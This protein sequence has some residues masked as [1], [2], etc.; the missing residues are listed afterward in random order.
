MTKKQTKA[1][2]PK[3]TLTLAKINK[4]A[5]S[6]NETTLFEFSNGEKLTINIKFSDSKIEDLLEEYGVHINA[7]EE[8]MSEMSELKKQKFQIHFLH[9]MIIKHFSEL[10]KSFTNDST[11]ILDQFN[12]IIDTLY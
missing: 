5:K 6:N 1:T 7:F 11:K 3:S 12:A 2:K 10:K 8:H 4:Q 9:F